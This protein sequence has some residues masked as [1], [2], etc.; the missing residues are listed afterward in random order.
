MDDVLGQRLDAR[1]VCVILGAT[2]ERGV[3]IVEA[4]IGGLWHVVLLV[5]TGSATVTVKV[6]LYVLCQEG[7]LAI[8]E[9]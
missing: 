8:R 7:G 2:D 4:A 5:P 3:L 9:S 6:S 1:L